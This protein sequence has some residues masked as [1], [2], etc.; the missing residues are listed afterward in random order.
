[1]RCAPRTPRHVPATGPLVASSCRQCR[2]RG[3]CGGLATNI[4]CS[5]GDLPRERATPTLRAQAPVLSV[6][7]RPL[8]LAQDSERLR[9]ACELHDDVSLWVSNWEFSRR[10]RV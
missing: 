9:I 4:I 1:M 2:L 3:I 8:H 10:I 5:F 7:C 6:A